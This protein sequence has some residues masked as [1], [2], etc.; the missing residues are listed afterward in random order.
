MKTILNELNYS[1]L[2]S[3]KIKGANTAIILEIVKEG[4]QLREV[5][6]IID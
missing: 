1:D 6:N 2:S 5:T 3:L 4:V